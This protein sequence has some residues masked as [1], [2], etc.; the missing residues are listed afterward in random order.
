MHVWVYIFMISC[1]L[2]YVFVACVCKCVC[3]NVCMYGT[4]G[5][6][7]TYFMVRADLCCAYMHALIPL[8]HF[9]ILDARMQDHPT[10]LFLIA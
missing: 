4:K 9:S 5:S 7:H 8:I 3:T 2:L 1:V 10:G 6:L